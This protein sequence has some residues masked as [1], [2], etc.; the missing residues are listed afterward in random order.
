MCA[1]SL[2][3]LK[4]LPK[5]AGPLGF[6]TAGGGAALD[7]GTL[8]GLVSFGHLQHQRRV[9]LTLQP[10]AHLVLLPLRRLPQAPG[11]QVH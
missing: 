6:G 3:L 2:S 4:A 7:E 10:R 11:W 8:V 1:A 5:E 9:K